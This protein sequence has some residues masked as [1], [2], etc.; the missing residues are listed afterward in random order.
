MPGVV[1]VDQSREH[2]RAAHVDHRRGLEAA[3]RAGTCLGTTGYLAHRAVVTEPHR[4]CED[5]ELTRADGAVCR[6]RDDPAS[7][8]EHDN[9]CL[10]GGSYS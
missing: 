10:D 6:Q 8:S 3:R 7:D 5:V 4:A 2:Q 1:Q 9:P